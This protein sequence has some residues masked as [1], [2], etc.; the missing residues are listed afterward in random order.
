MPLHIV[1]LACPFPS[2]WNQMSR[3]PSTFVEFY[4]LI[5]LL[6]LVF[7][8]MLSQT[9]SIDLNTRHGNILGCAEVT[10]ALY[11]YAQQTGRY[12]ILQW[13]VNLL[14]FYCRAWLY[15]NVDVKSDLWKK[16]LI[17]FWIEIALANWRFH[18]ADHLQKCS[19]R[20]ALKFWRAS[21]LR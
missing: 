15:Y 3:F 8:K 13:I 20:T 1:L 18:L 2:D 12:R 21:Y 19:T 9:S 11:L 5:L 6:F 14:E 16:I 17:W 10:H 7:P 4:H